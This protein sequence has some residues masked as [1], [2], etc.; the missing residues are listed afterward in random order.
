MQSRSPL[1]RLAQRVHQSRRRSG[2]AGVAQR[3]ALV[4]LPAPEAIVPAEPVLPP[5]AIG[6]P[7]QNAARERARRALIEAR[8]TMSG[9]IGEDVSAA[10]L[11]EEPTS[12]ALS[13]DW[14]RLQA[15]LEE[16]ERERTTLKEELE[17][18][19]GTVRALQSRLDGLER[20]LPAE[21]GATTIGTEPTV[22]QT[23][24]QPIDEPTTSVVGQTPEMAP[25]VSAESTPAPDVTPV[26]AAPTDA[27]EEVASSRTTS[28]AVAVEEPAG[29]DEHVRDLRERVLRALRERVFAAGTVGTRVHVA[30]PPDEPALREMIERFNE[31]PLV[32]HAEPIDVKEGGVEAAQIRISLRAPMRWEQFGALL[33]RALGLPVAQGDVRWSQGAVHV[34]LPTAPRSDASEPG[35]GADASCA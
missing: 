35:L 20:M 1:G 7:E 33:E 25:D 22:E 10:A 8:R 6:T 30:P 31:D 23:A 13:P 15:Y 14:E 26:D 11:S 2:L 27:S 9:M 3:L 24:E 29:D 16:S 18:L 12:P 32:E 34:R 4:V 28:P 5:I 19:R 21:A 17:G